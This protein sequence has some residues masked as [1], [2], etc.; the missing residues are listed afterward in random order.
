MI[1]NSAVYR[2][3]PVGS[4]AED[5]VTVG[6]ETGSGGQIKAAVWW[7]A[8]GDVDA[9]EAEFAD[10]GEALAAAEAARALHGFAEVVVTLVDPSLWRAEWGRLQADGPAKEPI[11]DLR[12]TDISDGEAFALARDIEAERD[13]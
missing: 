4:S 6:I 5:A 7:S 8:K 13:A 3:V 2:Q 10:V 12:G 11:G 1:S 9:D